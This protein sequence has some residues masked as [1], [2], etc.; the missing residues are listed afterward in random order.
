MAKLNAEAM[1]AMRRGNAASHADF[2]GALFRAAVESGAT[3]AST[4][5]HFADKTAPVGQW[6]PTLTLTVTLKTVE[7]E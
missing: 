7:E 5:I 6:Y 3:K 4:D 1:A 2:M